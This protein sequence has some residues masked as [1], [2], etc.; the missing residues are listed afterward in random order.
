MKKLESTLPNMVI[1]LTGVTL[2]AASLLGV[3]QQLT[4]EP[5][6]QIEKQTLADGIKKVILGGAEGDLTVSKTDTI[7]T[8][9]EVYIVY[10][11]NVGGKEAGK[12]VK[13]TVTGFSPNLT[14]L[15]GFDNQGNILGYEILT[16]AETPGLGAKAG[17]WF[18]KGQKGDI[19][20][21]NPGQC[22]MTVSKD[23]G[24][25]DAITASTITSRAFLKAV[26]LEYN[27]IFGGDANTGATTK[28]ETE[29]A[30]ADSAAL[31]ATA[32]TLA[33][34]ADTLS[35]AQ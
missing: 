26:N 28:A 14:V 22:N 20:G 34:A 3:M 1:V 16:T 15:T 19:I 32:D 11:A 31:T 18:Q 30:P 25:I 6:A 21:K 7:A 17:Q 10:T 2:V 8:E 24:E 29:V 35:A 33:Q 9:K 23:G 27:A 13:T 4:K 12:A 5:I